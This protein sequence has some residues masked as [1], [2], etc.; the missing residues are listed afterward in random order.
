M[1]DIQHD[2][3]AEV[4][5]F[6]APNLDSWGG[7]SHCTAAMAHGC[8]S[9]TTEWLAKTVTPGVHSAALAPFCLT[10][11]LNPCFLF[12]PET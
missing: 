12:W 5:S 4:A 2:P 10:T 1:R 9:A 7:P 3:W 6:P 8:G 11:P